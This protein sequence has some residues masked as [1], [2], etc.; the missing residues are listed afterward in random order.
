MFQRGHLRLEPH[1]PKMFSSSKPAAFTLG[2]FTAL[3]AANSHHVQATQNDSRNLMNI[4][5]DATHRQWRFAASHWQ[6][7]ERAL[8]PALEDR[9]QALEGERI[10][11]AMPFQ[12]LPTARKSGA[13]LPLLNLWLA[14]K[15]NVLQIEVISL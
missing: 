6:Y 13:A 14:S 15:L 9:N 8:L 2:L 12:T 3:G 1:F 5:I 4:T 11:W 7:V 10:L